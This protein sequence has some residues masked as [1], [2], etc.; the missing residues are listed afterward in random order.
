MSE[1][2]RAWLAGFTATAGTCAAHDEGGA[3][4]ALADKVLKLVMPMA[5]LPMH[6]STQTL[7]LPFPDH[8]RNRKAGGE[9][10]MRQRKVLSLSDHPRNQ[11]SS[12]KIFQSCRFSLL[13]E[14][15]IWSVLT[16]R[17]EP[18]PCPKPSRI[19]KHVGLTGPSSSP[20]CNLDSVDSRLR[21]ARLRRGSGPGS[22]SLQ[23][24]Q[25]VTEDSS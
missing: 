4:A 24:R 13:S 22:P 2:A 9:C 10:K 7:S 17:G 19:P 11:S 6:V 25:T 21:D 12:P 18:P 1:L 5:K 23:Q 15:S 3:L 20:R 16:K 14:A 8:G